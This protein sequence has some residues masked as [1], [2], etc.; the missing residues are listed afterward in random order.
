MLLFGL[1]VLVALLGLARVA[2]QFNFGPQWLRRFRIEK[3][4]LY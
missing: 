2:T 4:T 3:Y 1:I